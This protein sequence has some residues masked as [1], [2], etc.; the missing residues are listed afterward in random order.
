MELQSLQFDG[1]PTAVRGRSAAAMAVPLGGAT[2]EDEDNSPHHMVRGRQRMA[3]GF[4]TEAMT[5]T[6]SRCC[7]PL[8]R[9]FVCLGMDL[10]GLVRLFLVVQLL[11]GL[12]LTVL[13]VLLLAPPFNEP[14][15][16]WIPGSGPWLELFDLQWS[17]R[18]R[19]ENSFSNGNYIGTVTGALFGVITLVLVICAVLSMEAC[20]HKRQFRCIEKWWLVYTTFQVPTFCIINLCKISTLCTYAHDQVAAGPKTL[21]SSLPDY[22]VTPS[23]VKITFPHVSLHC[24][25]MKMWFIE[26]TC[27]ATLIALIGLW[28]CWSYVNVR[29]REANNAACDPSNG[30]A[31]M[32]GLEY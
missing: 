10:K 1:S 29:L 13:H 23:P 22:F 3:S 17:Y 9:T 12:L 18:M 20:G 25:T 7:M 11:Y 6:V 2:T 21:A 30:D 24:G 28:A 31:A 15:C 32:Q 8:S 14:E 16:Y 4:S 27:M 26:C 5:G 19:G